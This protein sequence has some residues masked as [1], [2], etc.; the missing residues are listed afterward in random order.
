MGPIPFTA[1]VD[2]FRIYGTHD[3]DDFDEFLY[4]IR[5]MDNTFLEMNA[6]AMKATNKENK[7]GSANTDPKNSNKGRH[8]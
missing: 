7:G 2:Y 3:E 4:V 8:R 1:I 6:S 5:R